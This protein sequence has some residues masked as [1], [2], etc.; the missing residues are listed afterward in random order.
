MKAIVT[1]HS[2]GLGGAIAEEL[3]GRGHTVLG[4]ARSANVPLGARFRDALEQI[5]LDLADL[6]RLEQWIE[7]GA[8][9]RFLAGA[10]SVLLVNNAGTLQPIGRL[11]TQPVVTVAQAVALNVGAAL[12]LASAFAAATPHAGDRRIA[13]VSSGAARTPYAGWSIYCATKAALDHHARAVAVDATP[14]LRI[15]SIAPGVIETKMQAEIRASTLEQ[16]PLRDRFREMQRTGT[17]D[18][19]AHAAKRF[20]D[21]VLRDDFGKET[22]VD[23]RGR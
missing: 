15:C 17:L 1:G 2:R 18:S 13:H 11:E 6:K 22:V 9:E 12:I 3:L 7:R 8:L 5:E 14:N 19:P 23:L 10:D 4:V 20:V 16:F 21:H